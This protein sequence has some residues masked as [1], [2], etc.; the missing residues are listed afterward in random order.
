MA[1]LSDV[2]VYRAV[3]MVPRSHMHWSNCEMDKLISS[4]TSHSLP[5]LLVSRSLLDTSFTTASIIRLP[6]FHFFPS[7]EPLL[8]LAILK[9]LPYYFAVKKVS[10]H[11]VLV[12]LFRLPD[13]LP[14]LAFS[15][16]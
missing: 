13:G 9:C 14:Y 11:C 16:C 3:E 12:R 1:I 4:E 5:F 15:G 2:H 7:I 6:D 8:L 10:L